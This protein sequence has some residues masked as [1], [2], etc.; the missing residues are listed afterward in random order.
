[1]I[2]SI[3]TDLLLFGLFF[4]KKLMLN[5]ILFHVCLF[6]Y[7]SV[8]ISISAAFQF[9]HNFKYK[10]KDTYNSLKFLS[11]TRPWPSDQGRFFYFTS[12]ANTLTVY[13]VFVHSLPDF[14]MGVDALVCIFLFA[15]FSVGVSSHR[16]QFA[17]LERNSLV[18]RRLKSY[19]KI[20]CSTQLF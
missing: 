1:M 19:K 5:L 10:C 3:I 9:Y 4:V 8:L 13:G 14:K 18:K 17:T 6:Q 15:P 7:F 2:V 16:R 12:W 20:P 11:F